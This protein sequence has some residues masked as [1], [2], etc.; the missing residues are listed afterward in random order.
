MRGSSGLA[1]AYVLGLVALAA[2]RRR[3]GLQR[4]LVRANLLLPPADADW[5]PCVRHVPFAEGGSLRGGE[6]LRGCAGA[7]GQCEPRLLRLTKRGA[8]VLHGGSEITAPVAWKLATEPW[9]RRFGPPRM[10]RATIARGAL[11]LYRDG[12][13]RKATPLAQLAALSEAIGH[14][15]PQRAL[16]VN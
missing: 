12:A 10:Y 11:E 2:T 15:A 3:E 13:R 16:S 8:L 14:G 4:V 1:C 6:A 9:W 5:G 7:C